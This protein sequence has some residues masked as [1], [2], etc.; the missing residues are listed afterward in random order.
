M[1]ITFLIESPIALH[2]AI[3]Y[4]KELR[5]NS[6]R[7]HFVLDQRT[8]NASDMIF[9]DAVSVT[10]INSLAESRKFIE[11]IYNVLRITYTK[12]NFSPTYTRWLK[13]R[14]MGKSFLATYLTTAISMWGPKWPS[15]EINRRLTSLIRKVL[16]NPF[17]TERVIYVTNTSKP[18]LLCARDLRVFT[19]I[20]SWDHAGKYPIGHTSEIAF[21]W[22]KPLADDW[23]S[24][25]GDQNVSI[26]Y[27]IKL[28]YAINANRLTKDQV[29]ETNNKRLMYPV[30]FG[31]TSDGQCFLEEMRLIE[32]ICNATKNSGYKLLLKPKP[33]NTTRDLDRFLHYPHVEIGEYQVNGGKSNYDLSEDYNNLRLF[34][35]RKCDAVIN[36]GTTFAFDAAAYG[37]P[38]FQIKILDKNYFP[39]LSELSIFP[40]LNRHLYNNESIFVIDDLEQL[41]NQT[42]FLQ[43]PQAY[44]NIASRFSIYLRS[45]ILPDA[46]LNSSVSNAI[47]LCI[48]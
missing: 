40:H 14:L 42:Q 1:E 9:N 41:T 21:T 17:R 26:S 12:R 25:Q 23:R 4:I 30:T 28:D 39:F 8:I 10:D 45:W 35:L 20:E 44:L 5:R 13:Q 3:P 22:N 18:Y 47:A 16:T 38:V 19:I 7:I 33:N 43:C 37:L 31:A 2:T 34:E 48:R 32:Q 29:L 24:F 46:S 15:D 36:L 11:W 6:V 27:P